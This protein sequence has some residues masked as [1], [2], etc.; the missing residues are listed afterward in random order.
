MSEASKAHKEGPRD[1]P[2]EAQILQMQDAIRKALTDNVHHEDERAN[3]ASSLS[4]VD[5]PSEWSDL[6]IERVL[7][8]LESLRKQ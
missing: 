4:V 7:E 1:R 6:D 5:G 8:A 2:S 3:Q